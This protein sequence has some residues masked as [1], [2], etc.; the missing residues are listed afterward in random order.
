MNAVE[1]Q[2]G[3]LSET[4]TFGLSF[5]DGRGMLRLD[6]PLHAGP[7]LVEELEL[8]LTGL[9]FP[10]DISGGVARFRNR[11]CLLRSAQLFL[12][13]QRLRAWLADALAHHP[14]YGLGT[15]ELSLG[16]GS[17]SLAS[18]V[19]V[20]NVNADVCAHGTCIAAHDKLLISFSEA[21]LFGSL[22]LS[23]SRLIAL[24]IEGGGFQD[25]S[26]AVR[27]GVTGS[28]IT[29]SGVTGSG[30]TGNG[31][32]PTDLL[33]DPLD[34]VLFALLP[35][36]GWRL[37]AREHLVLSRV[38]LDGSGLR[39]SYALAETT[40][41]MAT[42]EIAARHLAVREAKRL[43]AEQERAL[44]ES[45][46]KTF[47]AFN[48]L[49]GALAEHPFALSRLL[50]AAPASGR[51]DTVADLCEKALAIDP[52]LPGAYAARAQLAWRDR[53]M[54]A[55]GE[56]V[57]RLA[58]LAAQRDEQLE[59]RI[60]LTWAA[61]HLAAT[62]PQTAI[63][64][65]EQLLT[66]APSNGEAIAALVRLHAEAE[67]WDALVAIRE[68]EIA[69]SD[70]SAVKLHAI[71]ALGELLRVHMAD[72][73]RARAAYYQAL[74]IDPDCE[75]ALRGLAETFIDSEDPL[76]AIEPLDQLCTI[77]QQQR[78]I[79][80]AVAIHTR[81]A[82]LFEHVGDLESALDRL[83]TAHK[84]LPKEPQ[85]LRRIAALL[86]LKG[87][88]E[89]AAEHLR[90]LLE[91]LQTPS[92]RLAVHRRLAALYLGELDDLR[93]AAEHIERGLTLDQL[94][95]DCIALQLELT[96]RAGSREQ[97]LA[98]L[99]QALEVGALRRGE[100]LLRRGRLLAEDG[101]IESAL[102]TLTEA[103]SENDDVAWQ[104]W[105]E[106]AL[107]HERRGELP[108]AAACWEQTLASSAGAKESECWIRQ[109]RVLLALSQPEAAR[110]ALTAARRLQPDDP[111]ELLEHLARV[112]AQLDD[113][114]SQ[115][116]A[117]LDLARVAEE[118]QD[119]E[120]LQ[121]TLVQLA[122]L[123][124]QL[125]YAEQAL[126]T[127]RRLVD[128]F[129]D[130]TSSWERL[131]L[132]QAESGYHTRARDALERAVSLSAKDANEQRRRLFEKLAE[133]AAEQSSLRAAIDD[134]HRALGEQPAEADRDRFWEG[135][136]RLHLRRGDPVAAA[137][138]KEQ[139]V[140]PRSGTQPVDPRSG[141]QP[142][143]PR[144]G[145]QPVDPRSGTQ[146]VDPRSGTQP[147]DPRS[148]TQPADPRSGTQPADGAAAERAAQRL[149]EAGELWLKRAARASEATR[150]FRQALDFAPHH[151]RAL[152]ALESIATRS[153]DQPLL[154]E[155][156]KLKV[157]AA[158]ER[159]A[160]QKALLVR[161]AETAKLAGQPQDAR[162]AVTS[163]L[164][165]DERYLPALLLS[166]R[167]EWEREPAQ[168]ADWYRRVLGAVHT[169]NLTEIQAQA[170]QVEA[171]LRLADTPEIS[172]DEQTQHLELL[173]QVDPQH[174]PAL[175]R[176]ADLASKQQR[177]SDEIALRTRLLSVLDDPH[178]Q[179]QERLAL[180]RLYIS[181]NEPVKARELLLTLLRS[182]A[183]DREA[184][185]AIGPVLSALD[186]QARWLAL[187]ERR[188]RHLEDRSDAGAS[189]AWAKAA[190]VAWELALPERA[191]SAIT[192]SLSLSRAAGETISPKEDLDPN[193]SST[194]SEKQLLDLALGLHEE[195]Q[196]AEARCG[197]L[198]RRAEIEQDAATRLEWL[199]Q[200]AMAREEL[201]GTPATIELL[202]RLVGQNGEAA[203][204]ELLL[205]GEHL[206]RSGD[207]RRALVIYEQLTQTPLP[208]EE[209]IELCRRL[210]S[211]GQEVAPA[212][213][214]Q[215][216][217]RLLELQPGH[218]EGLS[219]ACALLAKDDRWPELIELLEKQRGYPLEAAA[220]TSVE[221]ELARALFYG[222][223]KEE[224]K[225]RLARL[226]ASLKTEELDALWHITSELKL[227]DLELMTLE[228]LI[229]PSR[230]PEQPAESDASDPHATRTRVTGISFELDADGTRKQLRA[231]ELYLH[232]GSSDR[233][234][235]LLLELLAPK[236][237]VEHRTQAARLILQ[238]ATLNDQRLPALRQLHDDDVASAEQRLQLAEILAEQ[239][240]ASDALQV[241]SAIPTAKVDEQ[242]LRELRWQQLRA[243]EDWPSLAREHELRCA[244]IG[245]KQDA[246]RGDQ[247]RQ[248]CRELLL[249][250]ATIW[251]VNAREPDE[252]RR[253]LLEQANRAVVDEHLVDDIE[254]VFTRAA[255]G[256]HGA[257]LLQQLADPAR[258]PAAIQAHAL[259]A[260]GRIY[261]EQAPQDERAEALFQEAIKR[262]PDHR[263]ALE[264]LLSLYK[265][266]GDYE[267]QVKTL[268]QLSTLGSPAERVEALLAASEIQFRSLRRASD[269]LALLSKA[270]TIAP[271]D[272]R[273]LMLS[274]ELHTE[275]GDLE[276]AEQAWSTLATAGE[277]PEQALARACGLARLRGDNEAEA[278]HLAR[279]AQLKPEDPA[280]PQRLL[281]AY[282]A[283]GNLDG[284]RHSLQQLAEHDPQA[285]L[286]LAELYA[287][288]LGDPAAA[289][290]AY[291]RLLEHSPNSERALEGMVTV[292][293]RLGR[294]E[295]LADSLAR[296]RDL[297]PREARVR[298]GEL[299]LRLATVHAE[300]LAN[301]DAAI[302]AL[303]QALDDLRTGERW[304][305]AVR[306]L[307]ALVDDEAAVP[308][309]SAL[310][311]SNYATNEELA[312]MAS[313]AQEAGQHELA[314][315]AYQQLLSRDPNDP[316]GDELL[317][318][319][320]AHDRIEPAAELLEERAAAALARS[321]TEKA[322]ELL[323]ELAT[324][325][326]RLEQPYRR[327]TALRR[328]AIAAPGRAGVLEALLAHWSEHRT[329]TECCELIEEL[330]VAIPARDRRPLLEQ[331]QRLYEQLDRAEQLLRVRRDLHRLDPSNRQL[332]I[333]LLKQA[334]DFGDR[335]LASDLLK[336]ALASEDADPSQLADACARLATLELE[337]DLKV[338]A[339]QLVEKALSFDPD[340]RGA[341]EALREIGLA[342]EDRALFGEASYELAKRL[343]GSAKLSMLREAGGVLREI[344]QERGRAIAA[345]ELIL[346]EDP[347][348]QRASATLEALLRAAADPVSLADFLW[349]L[350]KQAPAASRLAEL[351]KLERESRR[352]DKEEQ[353]LRQMLT[354]R[355]DVPA[356]IE[357]LAE[358]LQ[359]Q[360]RFSELREL[361][362]EQLEARHLSTEGLCWVARRLGELLIEQFDETE[363]GEQRLA[364]A[365]SLV[366]SD[367]EA[368]QRL[369]DSY[370]R[371]GE[372]AKAAAALRRWSEHAPREQRAAAY[373]ELAYLM[374]HHVADPLAA[375][376]AFISAYRHDRIGREQC[377]LDGL[378][379]LLAREATEKVLELIDE[380]AAAGARCRHELLR[381]RSSALQKAG[382]KESALQT[383]RQ[384]LELRP[385]DASTQAELG[386]LLADLGRFD[387][388]TPH[389]LAASDA[390]ENPR[391][392]AEA[393]FAA[394]QAL[395]ALQ[396]TREALPH[397]KRSVELD[398]TLRAAWEGLA[399]AQRFVGDLEGLRRSLQAIEGMVDK[400]DDRARLRTRLGDAYAAAGNV[401]R[402][403]RWWRL[404]LDDSPRAGKALVQLKESLAKRGSW[405]ECVEL[406]RMQLAATDTPAAQAALHRDLAGVLAGHLEDPQSAIEH[407]KLALALVPDDDKS[408][409]LL[410]PLLQNAGRFPEA[411]RLAE[412][413]AQATSSVQQKRQLIFKAGLCYEAGGE[414]NESMRIY[415]S[416][417]DRDD[418]ISHRAAKRLHRLSTDGWATPTESAEI[419]AEQ[420]ALALDS[421]SDW[422]A[423]HRTAPLPVV[424][425]HPQDTKSEGPPEKPSAG[426]TQRLPFGQRPARVPT[427][428]MPGPDDTLVRLAQN[429][430]WNKLVDE[431]RRRIGDVE[432]PV[433][434]AKLS[435]Q[436]ASVLEDR[437]DRPQEALQ[438]YEEALRLAPH[439]LEVLERAADAAYRSHSWRRAKVL[440]DKL[441][442]RGS[443]LPGAELSFRRGIVHEA[444]GYET[445]A[446]H[447]YNQA[448]SLDPEH[449]PALEARARLAIYRD[450][451][452]TAVEAL[453]DLLQL[454]PV[455]EPQRLAELRQHLGELHL[456]QG[457]LQAASEY[458]EA[459]LALDNRREK[460]MHLLLTVYEQQRN[461]SAAADIAQRLVYLTSE[462]S[463][464]ASLLHHRAEILAARLGNEQ[465]AIDCLLRA[466]DIAPHH[467][468]TLWRLLDYYWSR[469]DLSSVLQ[470]GE[471]L[472]AS[473]ALTPA[474]S[475]VRLVYLA[476][477][478]LFARKDR[479]AAGRLLAT[480]LS[481]PHQRK[482]VL[483]ELATCARNGGSAGALTE[484]LLEADESGQVVTLLTELAESDAADNQ[485]VRA[486]ARHLRG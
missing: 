456:G 129:P 287:D 316:R 25:D 172:E 42:G 308:L 292:C 80:N 266:R 356:V 362:R 238:S 437:L 321:K 413:M 441:W 37:P 178:K 401:E 427:T 351:A 396:L 179:R 394:A 226:A 209:E 273:V 111:R 245:P 244:N 20:G 133:L 147:V 93:S 288:A 344:P 107:L 200:A 169:A 116:Q 134:Y 190:E 468:P 249:S 373:Q 318:L 82:A 91:I 420:L 349:Q 331:L 54:Q 478:E 94:D 140:D 164:A 139:S 448:L 414:P 74:D 342:S 70:N 340:H 6:D 73:E 171:H 409:S 302:T 388:A 196:H 148:G 240:A 5:E 63:A 241:C 423:D 298:R 431:L 289:H 399:T 439:T 231:A 84:L 252:A 438:A 71:L 458:L 404:A 40:S 412:R 474:T 225:K 229:T 334:L 486:L 155:V 471:D 381:R 208:R 90:Q 324:V 295:A 85:P 472:R 461:Y 18:H 8:E 365:C 466:Y 46:E 232:T 304:A 341:W 12:S 290:D 146:P 180:A 259:C 303:E 402:A 39:L 49:D 97:I 475:D 206:H 170:L 282:R 227:P 327:E 306:Q 79:H 407:L 416:L 222:E 405:K 260:A 278:R 156:L 453:E 86:E 262:A 296:L 127:L 182:W 32:N 291:A 58:S 149:F 360:A 484:L 326:D 233:G 376:N 364:Q 325:C 100:L 130:Q 315:L 411:G 176:L 387:Q 440:Y 476:A 150:C 214:E 132:A 101:D 142:V 50:E 357:R 358:L 277:H 77:A 286:D 276:Q 67:R 174:Q 228:R 301:K 167:S 33:L 462:P 257:K 348:D 408:R 415:R 275:T 380:A 181:R 27:G 235:S 243:L 83:Q 113:P 115:L 126:Q 218:G 4:P 2:G 103:T 328:A 60:A 281:E 160:I 450:D 361:L 23:A 21:R 38:K 377:L 7:C 199:N 48:Q 26:H 109:A 271:E 372:F 419:S 19:E 293:Q 297:Q 309:Y 370:R 81:I 354:Q 283:A 114:Q 392:A 363:A 452:Q 463:L 398:P 263:G 447:C 386:H 312:S 3:H 198:A 187:L 173:L 305:Q 337:R 193:T 112:H 359:N 379:L 154:L 444:L 98:A 261:A 430:A 96:E 195:P 433:A 210:L 188:A 92:E 410:L 34:Y 194:A 269:A 313:R 422:I 435:L 128:A 280:I 72:H 254:R 480:A 424:S 207:K 69:R 15:I 78:D 24:M 350:Q 479:A 236:V 177:S 330:Y 125:G 1:K 61:R 400:G 135:I 102:D 451:P 443:T 66:I 137:E 279:L 217:L 110:D 212:R 369:L 57:M 88:H 234:L 285:L 274:A 345:F 389:L 104:A 459:A 120:R 163:A 59:Q 216:A 144:S 251:A 319:L 442:S 56:A 428:P 347:R 186:D 429:G 68:T 382:H 189:A 99:Q 343:D 117:L 64:L 152:D 390:L 87:N 175:T 320:L 213:T 311:S 378:D 230:T 151:K 131:G 352:Q 108:Q 153:N 375:A 384:C 145:T 473:G 237:A 353:A 299:A 355:P 470:M 35:P 138:A 10:F 374:Q 203:A 253:C 197:L 123:R 477:A 43:F 53:D 346:L 204:A 118:R 250:A 417:A 391:R 467:A 124:M 469:Q 482:A 393:A 329:P 161:L 224:A 483:M 220:L 317:P 121:H 9:S 339:R 95:P 168:A 366:P 157:E 242:R 300:Q 248:E 62:D 455:S 294:F 383:L 162:A 159:P 397:Y 457:N 75:P 268:E 385:D 221:T 255:F 143:D 425:T 367:A 223:Q 14:D 434:R 403:E 481:R 106:M 446:H 338:K 267:L 272:K 158:A 256:E 17:F 333:P 265:M 464:R 264:E 76:G 89:Q 55:Y 22:P 185:D 284:L 449:R 335:D 13:P 119:L 418:D 166:A 183:D 247:A 436:L 122:E 270:R 368:H 16:L 36:N 239:G 211:L 465:E 445:T 258:L 310:A 191:R 432:D 485:G 314:I 141:T 51:W 192:Q 215:A 201:S 47:F 332:I 426:D 44:L 52:D 165:I 395:E 371:R 136:V 29:G 246:G 28:G 454:V 406:V 30:V 205:F 45:D 105:K 65:Y 31:Q 307:L 41:G 323:M 219:V 184:L 421:S 460:A 336:D 202:E 11:R 322:G